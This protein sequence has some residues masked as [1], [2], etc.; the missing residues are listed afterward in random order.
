MSQENV[1]IVRRMYEHFNRTGELNLELYDPAIEW[2]TA[3]D[4]PDHQTYRG[5]QG[6]RQLLN[7]LLELWE[8]GFQIEPG[9]IVAAGDV[10]VVP[11]KVKVRGRGSGVELVAEET[12]LLT[13]REGR[14]IRVIRV[15]E[16]RTPEQALEAAGLSE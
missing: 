6:V 16:F 1:E 4:E 15:R 14:V 12:F 7:N 2:T 13:F 8:S 5:L 9:E 10:V 11:T 3:E